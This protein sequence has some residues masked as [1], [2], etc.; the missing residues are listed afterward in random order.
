MA[1]G[2]RKW[3]M[4]MRMRRSKN[5]FAVSMF[6]VFLIGFGVCYYLLY[7]QSIISHQACRNAAIWLNGWFTFSSPL[8]LMGVAIVLIAYV[9]VFRLV[10]LSGLNRIETVLQGALIMALVVGFSAHK[11][12][13]LP[14]GEPSHVQISKLVG[15]EWAIQF[16]EE[17]DAIWSFDH[18]AE[19]RYDYPPP[20]KV[21]FEENPRFDRR[22]DKRTSEIFRSK[23][24]PLLHEMA[25][26]KACYTEWD[27]A[28]EQYSKDQET[29]R[30]YWE[31]FQNWYA[32]HKD[33]YERE[34]DME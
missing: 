6:T 18:E 3:R 10:S 26:L 20:P 31:G 28:R 27:R 4:R 22:Y 1:N 33:E 5:G 12:A 23:A 16:V 13:L 25:E 2:F 17:H 21:E 34:S 15:F 30:D 24:S 29:L 32:F 19:W 14:F 11:A 9:W 8:Q 7:T